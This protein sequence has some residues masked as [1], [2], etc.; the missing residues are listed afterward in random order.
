VWIQ[1]TS[2]PV[3]L[4]PVRWVVNLSRQCSRSRLNAGNLGELQR[5]GADPFQSQYLCSRLQRAGVNIERDVKARCW[6]WRPVAGGTIDLAQV[7]TIVADAARR[8]AKNS[9]VSKKVGMLRDDDPGFDHHW[10][11]HE[12]SRETY[13]FL[14]T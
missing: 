11:L 1:V 13:E 12:D 5:I 14:G 10:P 4:S 2:G 8:F 3:R 9:S 6:L 7:E